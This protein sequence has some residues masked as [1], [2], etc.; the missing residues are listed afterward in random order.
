MKRWSATQE[1]P[2]RPELEEIA[3]LLRDGG[4]VILPTDTLYGFHARFDDA[5]AIERIFAT[6]ERGDTRPLLVICANAGQL[7]SLGAVIGTELEAAL[8]RLWPAALTAIVP[9]REPIPPSA[10]GT[11]IGARV[12][13]VAW[14][15]ELLSVT[16]P[17]ASTSV[18]RS[19]GA[20][21]TDP[22]D[23]PEDIAAGSDGIVDAGPL[24]GAPSTIVDFTGDTPRI[25]REGAFFFTQKLWKT[26]WKTL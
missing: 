17:L 9:L 22:T 5:A 12:P 4:V 20:P 24:E 15:R 10:G 14:L 3:A 21:L 18:N 25:V 23:L 13:D 16:G 2:A 7:R 6:K 8:N 26:V 1:G 19:G 11:T